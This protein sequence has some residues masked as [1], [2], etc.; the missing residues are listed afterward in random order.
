MTTELINTQPE[1]IPSVELEKINATDAGLADLLAKADELA[2]LGEYDRDAYE[3]V[4]RVTMVAVK[5]RTQALSLAKDLAAPHGAIYDKIMAEG[6]RIGDEARKA[7]ALLRP[8]KETYE[9][10]EKARKIAE[11]K[12]AADKI[13]DRVN[14]LLRLGA[15]YDAGSY[16]IGGVV[17]ESIEVQ[18]LPDEPWNE[19]FTKA[20]AES[21]TIASRKRQEEAE[22]QAE[23]DRLEK[24][25]IE[26]ETARLQI[27]QQQAEITKQRFD[28][29]AELLERDG[30]KRVSGGYELERHGA[31][32]ADEIGKMDS[33]DFSE[34]VSEWREWKA[35]Q[36]LE[37]AESEAIRQL[38]IKQAEIDEKARIKTDKERTR[39]LRADKALLQKWV[40]RLSN[41][42]LAE[43]LEQPE[44]Q[45]LQTRLIGKLSILAGELRADID[46]L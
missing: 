34:F 9:E 46:A 17:I 18:A 30:W 5:V 14:S 32:S 33:E 11:Q 28:W 1:V 23:A 39:R 2:A 3:E 7:E 35:Q 10:T 8:I 12:A 29:R 22:R 15:T 13:A 36:E 25:R 24:Q 41:F 27:E 20:V 44:T 21:E 37:K 40:T 16:T 42:P 38:N 19:L 4:H 26:Q 6:K 45:E 43:G 31:I